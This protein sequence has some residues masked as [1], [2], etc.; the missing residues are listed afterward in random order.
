MT[1]SRG[2]TTHADRCSFCVTGP[3]ARPTKAVTRPDSCP[4]RPSLP[5]ATKVE[6]AVELQ[7][8]TH[9]DANSVK[10]DALFVAPEKGNFGVKPDSPALKTGFRNFP[11]AGFG[12]TS[13]RL[14][15]LAQ[16]PRIVL[17][18]AGGGK[19]TAEPQPVKVLGAE[20]KLLTTDSLMSATGM[21]TKSGIF[22]ETVPANSGLAKL[23]FEV[24][25]VVLKINGRP[26]NKT[27]QFVRFITRMYPGMHTVEIWRGQKAHKMNIDFPAK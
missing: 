10:G 19:Q 7:E 8:R 3:Y 11:M 4:R 2:P 26:T 22:L 16:S 14:K 6:P 24:D 27:Q 13:E 17:P 18:S 12:V 21:H 25:D 15:V 20:V 1:T 23:G 9:D 5:G